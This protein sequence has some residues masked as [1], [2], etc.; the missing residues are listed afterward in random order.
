MSK[1]AMVQITL[2]IS[3]ETLMHYQSFPSYTTE[4]RKVL[5]NA[6]REA[7]EAAIEAIGT[8]QQ[9]WQDILVEEDDDEIKLL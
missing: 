4:M 7:Q 9:R 1:K 8:D 6:A 2:R 3:E 5:T